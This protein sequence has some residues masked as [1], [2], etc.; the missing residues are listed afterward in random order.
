M[1][2]DMKKK[3]SNQELAEIV[4]LARENG[5]ALSDEMMAAF[6]NGYGYYEQSAIMEIVST[7]LGKNIIRGRLKR[8][9]G[10]EK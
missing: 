5:I 7:A 10:L 4:R 2:T 1:R 6:E 3:F 9:T 8:N